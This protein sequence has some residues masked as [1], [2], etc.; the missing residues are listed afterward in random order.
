MEF[1]ESWRALKESIWRV[2]KSE[3]ILTEFKWA[4]TRHSKIWTRQKEF[5][6]SSSFLKDFLRHRQVILSLHTRFKIFIHHFEV[7]VFSE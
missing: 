3:Y 5:W 1:D 4:W 6:A 2:A 7:F